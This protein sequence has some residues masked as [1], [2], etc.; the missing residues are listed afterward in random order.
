MLFSLA[1]KCPGNAALFEARKG[2]FISGQVLPPLSGVTIA[3]A[4]RD[5]SADPVTIE[6]D[7]KGLYRVGP[8]HSSAEY[9]VSAKKL[10]Y[11]L[12]EVK[13]KQGHFKAHK[14]AEVIVKVRVIS[15]CFSFFI[16]GG[17]ADKARF[18]SN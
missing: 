11:V 18:L 6:T 17:T 1:D 15:C 7:S 8:L 4:P 10:G 12:S 5:K 16:F 13:G 3:I 2:V 9:E 14:L